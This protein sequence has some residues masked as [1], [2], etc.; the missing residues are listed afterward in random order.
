MVRPDP[1][2]VRSLALGAIGGAGLGL[3]GIPGGWLAG[4]ML[5]VAI[6]ALSGVEVAI[7]PWLRD[8]GFLAV[9]ISMGSG[10]TPETIAQL[11]SWPVTLTLVVLSIPL[12]AGAVMVFLMRIAG[13]SRAT[14][15]L[16]SMPGALSFL[17][18]IAPQTDADVP[19]VAI[20]QT[21]RV[22]ILVAIL[23]LAALW[24]SEPVPPTVSPPLGGAD[25]LILLYGA[26]IGGAILAHLL[27]VPG[28]L[29]IGGL[30]VSAG[31]HG[32][33]LVLGQ[34][35]QWVA[36]FG[37]IT[38]GV[39][40]GTRFAGS[41]WRELGQVLW[42]SLASFA[43]G[44]TIAILVAMIGAWLTGFSVWKLIVAFAPGGLEAMIVLAFA[45]DLDPA[46]VAAHH[47]VR[48]LLIALCAPFVIRS[49]GLSGTK[50]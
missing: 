8:L 18:A 6:A 15:M 9:G 2:V 43:L 24:L 21:M 20:V 22:S 13:W 10:V 33:G 40:I 41:R 14:A 28:G 29:L 4:A 3:L 5:V 25:D 17:L 46:F 42:V 26:G 1:T 44:M 27:G 16:S 47:L 49:F 50:P 37:F 12:I 36:I 35:P 39:L 23:P 34:P 30:F 11:P 7:A 19:R 48:F 32:T 31:L 45:M 38:L